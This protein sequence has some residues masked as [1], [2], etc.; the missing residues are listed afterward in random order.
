MVCFVRLSVVLKFNYI[1]VK[2]ALLFACV[3]L[4]LTA[5]APSLPFNYM[6]TAMCG[7]PE[8]VIFAQNC[9]TFTRTLHIT[10][11]RN[12]QA[13]IGMSDLRRNFRAQ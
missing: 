3:L 7:Y 12:A 1:D 11:T 5:I 4:F 8:S 13:Q 6:G 9:N 10:S 2:Y